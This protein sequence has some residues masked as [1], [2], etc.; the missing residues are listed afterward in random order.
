MFGDQSDANA[1][2]SHHGQHVVAGLLEKS[3]GLRFTFIPLL[4]W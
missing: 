2:R 4:I 1:L 3:L